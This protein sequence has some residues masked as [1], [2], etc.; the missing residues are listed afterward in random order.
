MKRIF[1]IIGRSN[2]EKVSGKYNFGRV[3][4]ILLIVE[5]P[6]YL[7]EYYLEKS[8]GNLEIFLRNG[9]PPNEMMFCVILNLQ[10]SKSSIVKFSLLKF[11][12]VDIKKKL[13]IV[14]DIIFQKK[15][16]WKI[17]Y[18]KENAA[19]TYVNIRVPENVTSSIA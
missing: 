2:Y 4:P 16:F 11:F 1:F 6:N 14:Y 3:H 12:F 10:K 18:I 7:S 9:Y 15:M 17:S 19:I 8:S 5:E 13:V